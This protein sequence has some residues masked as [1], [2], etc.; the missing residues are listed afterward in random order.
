[1]LSHLGVNCRPPTGL[2]ARRRGRPS[3]RVCRASVAVLRSD[4]GVCVVRDGKG[5]VV[6]RTQPSE[7]VLLT[8]PDEVCEGD[9]WRVELLNPRWRRAGRPDHRATGMEMVAGRQAGGRSRSL[10]GAAPAVSAQWAYAR[11]YSGRH[12]AR[13][14]SGRRHLPAAGA[15]THGSWGTSRLW[16]STGRVPP[17]GPHVRR[18]PA[19]PAGKPLTDRASQVAAGTS[20]ECSSVTGAAL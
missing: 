7:H 13:Y 20:I 8:D 4:V 14:R 6:T 11:S 17:C 1:L 9:S 18:R 12:R 16:R 19:R 10:H 2:A 15:T 5:V 3:D